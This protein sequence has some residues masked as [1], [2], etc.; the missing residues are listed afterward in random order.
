[1]CKRYLSVL[2]LPLWPLEV[3]K[4]EGEALPPSLCLLLPVRG[5]AAGGSVEPLLKQDLRTVGRGRVSQVPP[6]LL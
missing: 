1:M 5:E 4:R 3:G 2:C 6:H